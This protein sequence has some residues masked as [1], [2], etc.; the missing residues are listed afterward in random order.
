M[1]AYPTDCARSCAPAWSMQVGDGTGDEDATVLGDHL[2]VAANDGLHVYGA[3]PAAPATNS[4]DV[5]SGVAVAIALVVVVALRDCPCATS[6]ALGS[7]IG[8]AGL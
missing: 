2:Y 8:D 1:H 3:E 6:H 7:R 5:I 4:F